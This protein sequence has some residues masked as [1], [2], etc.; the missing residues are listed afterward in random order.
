MK[1]I[2]FPELKWKK[3]SAINKTTVGSSVYNGHY[4]NWDPGYATDGVVKNGYTN[5]FHSEFESSPWIK[6]DLLNSFMISCV[7]V[8]IRGDGFGI[9][10]LTYL[11]TL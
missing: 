2:S 4:G 5:M 6:V 8:F 9:I 10:F 3:N 11:I 7:R 1:L